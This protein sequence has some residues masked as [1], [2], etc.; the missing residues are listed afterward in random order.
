MSENKKLRLD[1]LIVQKKLAESKTQAQALIMAGKVFCGT[2]RLDK[3]GKK[4]EADLDVR[5]EAPPRFVSRGGEKLEAAL[6]A[7][8]Q[9]IVSGAVCLDV[10]ASTGGFTDCLLQRGAREV[11][12]IDVG[13]GQM[14]TK[15]KNDPR[16][17]SFEGINARQMTLEEISGLRPATRQCR[18]LKSHGYPPPPAG[19]SLRDEGS[20]AAAPQNNSP[21]HSFSRGAA[22]KG[23]ASKIPFEG[24]G[25][26]SKGDK[27]GGQNECFD[28]VVMD[29]AFISQKKVL[30]NVWRFV[31]PGGFFV[32]LI[33]PQFEV[34]KQEADKCQGVV[35]DE[36][37]RARV[38][39]EVRAFAKEKLAGCVEEKFLDSPI[40][41]GEG[42]KEYLVAWRKIG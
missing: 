42:N 27:G 41:G 35:K 28:L 16:V 33:K 34:T 24:A 26:G 30:E 38:V 21:S 9:I 2:Q 17:K 4:V 13:H 15:I 31:K 10:G 6:I 8:P 3:A 18:G 19:A 14:H 22:I 11:V 32:S 20:G 40:E 1:D 36:A 37:V 23:E 29:L 7:C 12:A 5:V 25:V 39:A